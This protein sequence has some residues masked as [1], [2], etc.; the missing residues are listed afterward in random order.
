[1]RASPIIQRCPF[2]SGV[3]GS[4]ASLTPVWPWDHSDSLSSAVTGKDC[5]SVVLPGPH[6]SLNLYYFTA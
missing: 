2:V 4:K 6:N 3:R 1:M 5:I